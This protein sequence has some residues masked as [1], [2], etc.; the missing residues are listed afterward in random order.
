MSHKRQADAADLPLEVQRPGANQWTCPWWMRTTSECKRVLL[1]SADFIDLED[2]ETLLTTAYTLY[3]D[4]KKSWM[5]LGAAL[6]MDDKRR[7]QSCTAKRQ[8]P[9]SRFKKQT[10]ISRAAPAAARHRED[11]AWTRAPA[12]YPVRAIPVSGPGYSLLEP[13][14]PEWTSTRHIC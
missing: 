7:P 8:S 4:Q 9:G 13:K 6:K 12:S 2:L 5:L 11:E 14:T 1:R 3:R 10:S